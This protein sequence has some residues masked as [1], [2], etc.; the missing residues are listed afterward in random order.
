[1]AAK[2]EDDARRQAQHPV[3]A[4]EAAEAGRPRSCDMAAPMTGDEQDDE[5]R[6]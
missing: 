3:A 6:R 2:E 4:R 5:P 1:M